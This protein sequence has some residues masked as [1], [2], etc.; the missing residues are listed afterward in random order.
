MHPFLILPKL[1]RGDQVAIVSPSAGL[2]ELFPWVQELGLKRLREV[3]GLHPREYPTTRR[4][5]APLPDRAQDLMRAFAD[6][7]NK[8]VFTS[9]G[10]DDQLQLLKHL[11]PAVFL[12]NPKPFFG[13]SDHTHL[14]TFLWNLGIPSYYGVA[15]MTQLAMHQQMHDYTVQSLAHALFT[16]GEVEVAAADGYTDEGLEWADPANLQRARR[17]EVNEGWHW[18]GTADATGRLWGGCV[19][20]LVAQVAAE[21]Y[22]PAAAALPGTILYL[23]TSESLPSA[24]VL[25]YLL[26]GFGERGW[27][28]HFQAVLVGRPK[29]WDF[30][31]PLTRAQKA[32]YCQQQRAAVVR[33]VRT[34]NPRIPI[35]QNID[36]GHTDPQLVLPSGQM[37]R[38]LG[39]EQ[40]LFL[41]Y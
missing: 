4:M 31:Q 37:A 16:T 18:D 39:T 25:D 17:L 40:R 8:A 5:Q 28:Q 14:H 26:T 19:E 34:Y 10:G 6:P 2:P 20:S 21:K 33:A 29:A 27:L 9:I 41:T 13:Y 24:W 30:A 3:F 12:A 36:F 7:E 22:L 38:V 23:E 11:D 32:A 35:I 15:V 1:T